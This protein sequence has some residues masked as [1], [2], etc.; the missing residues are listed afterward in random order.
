MTREDLETVVL[1]GLAIDRSAEWLEKKILGVI[2]EIDLVESSP[3]TDYDKLDSLG[4]ELKML[5]NRSLVESR[6][7]EQFGIKYGFIVPTGEYKASTQ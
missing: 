4:R 6:I 3:P 1:Q 2:A 7:S 5:Y